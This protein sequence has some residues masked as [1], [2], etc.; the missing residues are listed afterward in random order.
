MGLKTAAMAC[1]HS[2]S[3]V[4]H[5]LSQDQDGYFVVNYLHDFIGI[6]SPD[7][8]F[9]DYDT[10]GSLLRDLGLQESPSKAWPPS[11]VL[12]CL[13]VEVNSLASTLSVT[14]EWLQ[15][16]ETLL[17]QW[18]TQRSAMKSELQSL[19]GKLLFVTKCVRQSRFFCPV[20]LRFCDC[21]STIIITLNFLRNFT[22]IFASGYVSSRLTM[23][24]QLFLCHSCLFNWLWRNEIVG[25][26]KPEMK[27]LRGATQ[28]KILGTVWNHAKDMLL[29]NV[30][31]P[32]DIT[33]TKRTVLSQIARIFGPV[34]LDSQRPS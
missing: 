19:V 6:S 25:Q 12:N 16:L 21:W 31:P 34:E 15:E 22:A 7:K 13:G 9:H 24:S 27:L 5:M 23:V 11:P 20:F 33:L 14:P 1:Q 3:A 4:C 17:L 26:E 18:T 10:C 29:L 30:N 2:T 28:E 32:N 8:A